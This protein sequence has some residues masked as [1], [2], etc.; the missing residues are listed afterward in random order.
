MW[1]AY[2]SSIAVLVILAVPDTWSQNEALQT[3]S[4]DPCLSSVALKQAQK[5]GQ[6]R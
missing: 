1:G 3:V 4:I 2:F 5:K 6:K